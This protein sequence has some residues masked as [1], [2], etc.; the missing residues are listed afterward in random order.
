LEEARVLLE[1]STQLPGLFAYL[2]QA[3]CGS[4][5]MY[6]GDARSLD[7]YAG[8]RYG[9]ETLAHEARAAE[10]QC[11]QGHLLVSLGQQDE[12]Y[13]VL[14]GGIGRLDALGWSWECV[15]DRAVLTEVA[16]GRGV[17]ALARVHLDAASSQ[18]PSRA[19]PEAVPVLR[20]EARL[21]Q[22]LS[23]GRS[24]DL[25]DAVAYA[26]R[27]RGLRSRAV[28]GWESLTPSELRVA[29]LVGQHLSNTE[30]AALLFVST[31]TVRSHL[32]RVFAKLGLSSRAQLTAAVLG[33]GEGRESKRRE[34]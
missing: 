12:G 2:G 33:R 25:K 9:A 17:L 10:F 31:T 5:Y 6:L 7:A 34:G 29:Y 26:R 20:A 8:A 13:K 22:A 3:H 23:E 11:L 27:G 24:L 28:S 16:M 30:I 18:V 15:D 32:N 19:E 4:A 21:E 14:E 1:R